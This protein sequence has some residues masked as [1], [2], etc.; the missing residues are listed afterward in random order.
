MIRVSVY[1]GAD[2]GITG[3]EAVD[4]AGMAPRGQDIVCAGVSA[5][6]DT[7]FLGLT[8]HLEREVDFQAANGKLSVRLKQSP[9][10]LSDAILAT[11]LLGIKE[12]E[13]QYPKHVRVSE[14]RR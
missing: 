11:M 5:L 9:D 6:T 8:K 4:H 13:K 7:A 14:S 12:I 3:F 10:S 1:W 2:G